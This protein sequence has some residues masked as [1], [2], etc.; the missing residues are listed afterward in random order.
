MK[1]LLILTIAIVGGCG[2]GEKTPNTVDLSDP[3]WNSA[4]PLPEPK[5]PP[6]CVYQKAK[7]ID[8]QAPTIAL[9]GD[10][11]VTVPLGANYLDAGATA[12][13]S[14]GVD[15]S[16]TIKVTGLDKIDTSKIADYLIRYEATDEENHAAKARTRIVRVNNDNK[17]KYSLR[18]F[19]ELNSPM[20][21]L[22]HLPSYIG[23]DPKERYPLIIFAH[24]WGHYI[25]QA[26]PS[27]PLNA[28]LEGA[29][30]YRVFEEGHWPDTRPFIVLEPQRCDGEQVGDIEWLQVDQFI[31]WALEAYPIDPERIYMMGLSAGGYFTYRYPV[32]FPNRLAAIA[33]MSAG[34]PVETDAART[35]FCKAMEQMPIWAFH[36]DADRTVPVDHTLYTF[37]IL[38]QR[39]PKAPSPT[40]LLTIVTRGNHVIIDRIDNDSYIGQGDPKYNIQ[41]QSLY[42]WFLRYTRR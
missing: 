8:P 16:A 12:S 14:R 36:G 38:N 23:A 41:D 11:V 29:N 33:P 37:E 31:D 25:Q 3:A 7:I 13:D 30:I 17:P 4:T 9:L 39:C 35:A 2:R 10:L 20:G 1:I 22:E 28:L 15:L 5:V 26:S 40:P 21:Y 34:G 32:L 19:G 6:E 18:A 24:G 42:D 27:Q